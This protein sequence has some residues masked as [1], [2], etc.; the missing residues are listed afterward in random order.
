M[1]HICASNTYSFQPKQTLPNTCAGFQHDQTLP[2]TSAGVS[3]VHPV[4]STIAQADLRP[5]IFLQ[6]RLAEVQY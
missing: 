6:P 3:G 1:P 5:D 4:F 2:N